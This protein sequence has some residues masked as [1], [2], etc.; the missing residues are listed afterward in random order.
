MKLEDINIK[1]IT[2][3]LEGNFNYYMSKVVKYPQH[4]TEQYFY[5]LY[6]CKDTCLQTGVCKGCG[7]P[8]I[9]KA[10]ASEACSEQ[11]KDFMP[12]QEWELHKKE[13]NIDTDRINQMIKEVQDELQ[14]RRV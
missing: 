11:F 2:S 14:K 1:N 4:L 13:A 9:Q 10:F 6:I 12:G 5:R 3:F 7:C 8:T